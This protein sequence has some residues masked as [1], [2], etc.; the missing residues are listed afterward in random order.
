MMLN[1]TDSVWRVGLADWGSLCADVSVHGVTGVKAISPKKLQGSKW[2]AVT[3]VGKSKHFMVIELSRDDEGT[4]VQC[5]LE[6]VV[7]R[8][9][10][11]LP[12]RELKDDAVWQQGWH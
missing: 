8:K 4:V 2:T 5:L 12:W 9:T 10:R 3:P 7:T 6:A 11:W 1:L